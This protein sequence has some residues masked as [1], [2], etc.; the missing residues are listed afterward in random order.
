MKRPLSI[1]IICWTNIAIN[2]LIALGMTL[3]ILAVGT[4]S[5]D[6]GDFYVL[7]LMPYLNL[8][9]VVYLNNMILRGRRGARNVFMAW[10]IFLNVLGYSVFNDI[11]IT[12]LGI[13][14][15]IVNIV[16]LYHSS[17]N[18]FFAKKVG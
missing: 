4:S 2:Y 6:F 8:I 17:A 1:P 7:L 16:C 13:A 3:V 15:S 14:L 5:M 18:Q 11:E 9:L 12:L 10:C